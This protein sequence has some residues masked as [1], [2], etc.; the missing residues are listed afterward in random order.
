MFTVGGRSAIAVF[1]Y[2]ALSFVLFLV[3]CGKDYV[4]EVPPAQTLTRDAN[5]YYCLMTVVNHRGPKGQII[6]TDQQQALWFSSVRDMISFTLLPGEPKN[7]AAMYV[8]DMTSANWD[9]PGVDNWI[10]ARKAW[11]VLG[12]ERT[13]GMGASEAIP[14]AT[15]AKAQSFAERYGGTVHVLASIP[16]DYILG[17]PQ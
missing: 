17:L 13:G 12:S 16:R 2:S 7:I 1:K 3:S 15:K 4:L 10:D 11:Y 6:L 14:F 9:A 8:N 5:G